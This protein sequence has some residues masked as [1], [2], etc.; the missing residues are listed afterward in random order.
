MAT[1]R[2]PKSLSERVKSAGSVTLAGYAGGQLLRLL[3][4]L[5]LARLLFPEAFGT[6]AILQAV[7]V[8][9]VM[10]TDVGLS[11]S[12]MRSHRGDETAFLN[13]IW[14]LQII[15]GAV[16]AVVAL[17][18]A[19]P[20]A[21]WYANEDMVPMLAT[22]GLIAFLGSFKSTKVDHAMRHMQ[23]GRL[24][25]IEMLSQVLQFVIAVALALYLQSPWALLLGNMGY[26]VFY[27]VFSHL[28]LKGPTNRLAWDPGTLREIRGFSVWVMLSSGVTYLSGEGLNLLRAKWLDL[29][30]LGQLSIASALT[31]MAWNAIQKLSAQVL[32]PA[33]TETL[34]LQPEL[35]PHRVRKSRRIQLVLGWSSSVVLVVLGEWL[36]GWLY[37]D[38]YAVAAQ[39]VQ[40]TATGLV[41][42]MLSATYSGLLEALGQPR[43]AT[44]LQLGQGLLRAVGIAVGGFYWGP[45][46]VV[47]SGP[48]VSVCFY[49]VAAWVHA[50]RGLF[51]LWSD[52]LGFLLAGALAAY[53]Y[54]TW[55][56]P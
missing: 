36:V 20:V 17:A 14:T 52:V 27:A 25:G 40:I 16:V 31:L 50:K 43:L 13:T 46:G 39:I 2:E 28:L 51:D 41:V 56:I 21:G 10:L 45:W 12:V 35:L 55:S 34:R 1:L 53:V 15:K 49:P 19:L 29:P 30:F 37:D 8:G 24:V 3:S 42:S 5:V 4:N 38:R 22:I 32:F 7:L 48:L 6:M 18:L 9:V 11:M 44:Y 33:Y 26:A 47:I 54:M 23:A